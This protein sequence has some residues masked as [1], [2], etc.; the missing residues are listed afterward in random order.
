MLTLVGFWLRLAAFLTDPTSSKSFAMV[1][2]T[3]I[4]VPEPKPCAIVLNCQSIPITLAPDCTVSSHPS[5]GL[6]SSSTLGGL[7][8]TWPQIIATSRHFIR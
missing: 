4:H 3:C 5:T 8:H 7:S 1:L 2:P 6:P